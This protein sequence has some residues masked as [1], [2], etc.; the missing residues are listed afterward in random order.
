MQLYASHLSL[1]P[2][3]VEGLT[4]TWQVHNGT[5]SSAD[6]TYA[7]EHLNGT[8]DAVM[9]IDEAA[10]QY[11]LRGTLTLQP[12]ALLIGTLFPALEENHTSVATLLTPVPT[13]SAYNSMSPGNGTI[14][15]W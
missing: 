12:F 8:L 11:T 6:G 5:L 2:R 10:G 15:A 9:T 4:V 1:L 3:Q 13:Q 14:S 7:S